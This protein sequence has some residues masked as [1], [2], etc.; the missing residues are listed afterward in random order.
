MVP[1]MTN[2]AQET[3]GFPQLMDPTA[4]GVRLI[5]SAN[6]LS[7]LMA[8]PAWYQL[9]YVEGRR[10]DSSDQAPLGFGSAYHSALEAGDRALLSKKDWASAAAA[11]WL[12]A[13]GAS[14]R[15]DRYRTPPALS[16]AVA[17]YWSHWEA[18]QHE[19]LVLEKAFVF[20]LPLRAPCGLP[21]TIT[22]RFDAL[23]KVFGRTVLLERKHTTK[24]LD[25]RY[26][27]QYRT[28]VQT[29]TY[30]LGAFEGRGNVTVCLDACKLNL[31]DPKRGERKP[32]EYARQLFEFTAAELR[33]H[34]ED[35]VGWVRAAEGW[36]RSGHW[37][38]RAAPW[39]PG[40]KWRELLELPFAE[41]LACA[42]DAQPQR[43]P[44]QSVMATDDVAEEE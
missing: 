31:A 20:E 27:E 2:T 41:R 23:A 13:D 17:G 34:L 10:F 28:A 40:P 1:G 5:H 42:P 36:A 19:P 32:P 12:A 43:H 11:S 39:G 26:W 14:F 44:M 9:M 22:G 33:A 3:N 38:R 24:T 37:P 18:T 4:P 15:E 29:R 21:Y 16:T 6:S 30:A 7:T 8:D 25:R 35:I